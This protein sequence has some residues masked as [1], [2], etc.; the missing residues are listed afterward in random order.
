[1]IPQV[2]FEG[3]LRKQRETNKA[4]LETGAIFHTDRFHNWCTKFEVEP[5]TIERK[6]RNDW[7]F[8]LHFTKEPSRQNIP[9]TIAVEYMKALHPFVKGFRKLPSG[10]PESK[11]I[12]QGG[13]MEERN[14]P[15]GFSR[16][17]KSI[18]FEW[19]IRDKDNKT[20]LQC[21]ATQKYTKDCG[22]TQD[23]V[24]KE[25]KDFVIKTRDCSSKEILFFAICDGKY[26]TESKIQELREC[27]LATGRTKVCGINE[28]FTILA[29]EAVLGKAKLGSKLTPE[30][31]RMLE[32][33][34]IPTHYNK[35]ERSGRYAGAG[36][37]IIDLPKMYGK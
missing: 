34:G 13:I 36:V 29:E 35:E 4:E 15:P 14:L 20:L 9:E 37:S 19:Q 27:T 23:S 17:A 21:Y 8:A 25:V 26:Y 5:E 31:N 3:A 28:V 2:D 10:G 30:V 32:E 33:N 22:G 18:D 7:L 16:S 11:H 1:M 6:I 12:I 24:F